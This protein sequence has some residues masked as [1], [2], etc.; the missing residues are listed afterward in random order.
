MDRHAINYGT[1]SARGSTC[2]PR[3]AST[4][5]CRRCLPQFPV[6]PR[7]QPSRRSASHSS[8]RGRSI[9]PSRI[10]SPASGGDP[11][12]QADR[13]VRDPG[14]RLDAAFCRG[15]RH[16]H[17]LRHRNRVGD[18]AHRS[19]PHRAPVIRRQKPRYR[20]LVVRLGDCPG[21][22]ADKAPTT[23]SG[24]LL[25]S[26]DDKLDHHNRRLPASPPA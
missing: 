13:L 11:G 5:R 7:T 10:M 4:R 23:L 14:Q 16:P 26:V 20:S 8:V 25:E 2:T 15:G 22:T 6:E 18:L 19:A 9:S 21:D 1:G 17:H 12:K 24:R 3:F